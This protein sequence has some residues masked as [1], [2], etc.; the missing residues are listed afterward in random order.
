MNPHD[1][2]TWWAY[3]NTGGKDGILVTIVMCVYVRKRER[4]R[5]FTAGNRH[6]T[7]IILL[8]IPDNTDFIKLDN[9]ILI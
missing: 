4:E 1:G 2:L 3:S 6:I 9:I 5:E 7:H 8:A